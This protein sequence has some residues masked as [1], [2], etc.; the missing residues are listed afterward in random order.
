MEHLQVRHPSG[1]GRHPTWTYSVGEHFERV[2][3]AH[4]AAGAE[5]PPYPVLLASE[6]D[7]RETGRGV[8][9]FP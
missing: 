8:A 7:I 5:M 1:G 4:E 3:A 6:A 9:P 2:G